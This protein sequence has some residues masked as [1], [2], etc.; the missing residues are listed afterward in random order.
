MPEENKVIEFAESILA[1]SRAKEGLEA[2]L[3]R[4]ETLLAAVLLQHGGRHSLGVFA[5]LGTAIQKGKLQ[6]TYGHEIELVTFDGRAYHL[7]KDKETVLNLL[8]E[9][10]T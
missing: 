10:P 3:R 8:K 2:D 4:T 7:V 6:F 9:E 5:G 1:L